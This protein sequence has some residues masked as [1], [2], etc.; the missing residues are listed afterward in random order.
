M[1]IGKGE[2]LKESEGKGSVITINKPWALAC[3]HYVCE[4]PRNRALQGA[5][6]RNK[7][8]YV[9]KKVCYL[10]SIE[11]DRKKLKVDKLYGRNI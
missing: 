4:G 11:V 6:E 10:I 9:I 5:E 1:F 7:K 3:A 8:C 2:I